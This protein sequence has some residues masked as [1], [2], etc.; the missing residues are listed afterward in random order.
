[1]TYFCNPINVPYRYQFKRD[2]RDHYRLSVNREAADPSLVLFQGK[3]Y[4]FASMSASVWVSE[5]LAHWMCAALPANVPVYDY[6]PDVRVIGEWLYFTASNRGVPCSFYRTKD[7]VHGPYEEIKGSFDYWDPNLFLDDDGRVYFYWG[8]ANATPIWGVE[9]DRATMQP[10][11]DKVPLI[12][13]DPWN[14]GYE[15]FGEDNSENPRTEDQINALFEVF[16][17]EQTAAGVQIP[18]E[19]KA[20]IRATFAGMPYIEGAWMTK[21]NGKYYLQYACPG[22]ELNVYADGVSVSD[23]PLGPFKRAE[24]NPFSYKPGGFLPGAGH[25]STLQDQTGNWWHTATMRVSV[26]HVFE[27][28]V[29]LWP[30]GFDTDGNLFCN[31]RYGDWPFSVEQLSKDV[32]ADPQ[33]MLLSFGK[34]ASAS[35]FAA[36]RSPEFAVDENVQTW[37]RAATATPGE[38]L[39]VDLGCSMTVYAVQVNFA[40]DPEVE[41][42]CPGQLVQTPDMMRYIDSAEQPTRWRLEYSLDGQNWSVLADR[43]N[44]DTDLPHDLV[45]QEAGVSARYVRLV[46]RQVPYAVAP[47]ISGLRIFGKGRGKAPQPTDYTAKRTTSLDFEVSAAHQSDTAGYNILWGSRPDRLYHSYMVMGHCLDRKRIGGLIKGQTFY[48]R[49]DSF[50]ENGITIGKV[51]NLPEMAEG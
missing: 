20:I 4:L 11:A 43:W 45:V 51:V 9:L 29:G 1:M 14:Y 3:Y 31:Q 27:R 7:P 46:I 39:S 6:A 5:D 47:C 26:N 18:E 49:V 32:W 33:W 28:R 16:Q 25:G 34:T 22:A 13:G 17:Q 19:N 24:S 42:T 21:Y 37:W 36:G 44:T 8:C 10:K 35:S 30:A 48:V 12:Y 15:R 2:P 41:K 50:N 23:R 38:W 40:D